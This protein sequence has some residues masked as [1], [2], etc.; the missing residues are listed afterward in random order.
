VSTGKNEHERLFR[1]FEICNE[2][3][4]KNVAYFEHFYLHNANDKKV[5]RT[6][7]LTNLVKDFLPLQKSSVSNCLYI[8]N[9]INSIILQKKSCPFGAA[10]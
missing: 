1:V 3:I 10:L 7:P 4:L 8:M 2:L 5:Y 9:I 6:T